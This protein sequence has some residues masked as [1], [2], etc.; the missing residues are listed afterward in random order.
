MQA[1]GRRF[2]LAV[3]ATCMSLPTVAFAAT[4]LQVVWEVT[5]D[6]LTGVAQPSP[7]QQCFAVVTRTG[8]VRIVG[9]SG[10][11]VRVLGAPHEVITCLA[12]SPDGTRLLTGTATGKVL[13]WDVQ[14]GT[15]Q[16]VFE[17]SGVSSARV[18]WL[19]DTGRGVLEV[20]VKWE[21]L[22]QKPAGFVFDCATGK[23]LYTFVASMHMREYGALAVS[24]DGTGIAVL[25]LP[26]QP[27]GAFLLDAQQG[28]VKAVLY[29]SNHGSG[30]L[31]VAIGPD[32]ETVAVGYAPSDVILWNAPRE[33]MLAELRGHDNWVVSLAFSPDGALLVSGAGDGTARVWEVA[34]GQE[35]GQIGFD[36]EGAFPYVDS[37]GFS[38]DGKLVLAAAADGRIVIAEAPKVP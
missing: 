35:I 28:A 8:Q 22:K 9:F 31:S 20:Q 5:D 16:V 30:P 12:Y 1:V 37:V 6:Q 29:D 4:Q 11:A 34:T 19:G 38:S 13:V 10:Q 2:V 7:S 27:R 14:A 36:G 23:L 17:H 21:E 33:E 18:A 25:E 15:S 3:L 26:D 32:G 24:R